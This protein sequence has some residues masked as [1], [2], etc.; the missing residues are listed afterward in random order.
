VNR[1]A[2]ARCGL[3]P[4]DNDSGPEHSHRSQREGEADGKSEH[5][6]HLLQ[7]VE[8]EV[9]VECTHNKTGG[10]F[11]KNFIPSYI[12]KCKNM[13]SKKKKKEE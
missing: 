12:K 10:E 9:G 4:E 13:T 2:N 6:I 8:S 1:H 5:E 7:V 11:K 3:T